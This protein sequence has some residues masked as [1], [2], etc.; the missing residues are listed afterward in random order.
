MET[1]ENDRDVGTFGRRASSACAITLA[2]QTHPRRVR[3]LYAPRLRTLTMGRRRSPGAII[4]GR[5]PARPAGPTLSRP[6]WP[7]E[8][9]PRDADGRSRL[10]EARI[11]RRRSSSVDAFVA[12]SAR[13]APRT[14]CRPPSSLRT[15][16]PR[17]DGIHAGEAGLEPVCAGRGAARDGV[18][19]AYP[20]AIDPRPYKGACAREYFY[21]TH[22]PAAPNAPPKSFIRAARAAGRGLPGLRRARPRAAG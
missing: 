22:R 19:T 9:V 11:P 17:D 2:A 15:A 10:Q 7:I 18:V 3:G 5:S 20:R 1:P 4:V 12:C 8:S 13:A 14:R 21:A 6:R 16:A